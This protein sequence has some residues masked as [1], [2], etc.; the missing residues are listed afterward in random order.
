VLVVDD[1]D[2]KREA[3]QQAFPGEVVVF[4]RAKAME[5][6][7]DGDNFERRGVVYARNIC[8]DLARSLGFKH[9]IVLDDDYNSGFYLR[10]DSRL[11]YGNTPRIARS[12]DAIFEALLEFYLSTP[13][14]TVAFSQG[15]D[16]IGG[17][18]GGD[19]VPRLK[20]KAMNAF[21]C[22]VDRPF[23]F[24]GRTNEDVNAYVTLSRRGGLFFTVMQAQ[25]NQLA[26]QSNPGGLTELYLDSGTYV[27]SFYTVMYA[28][29]CARVGVLGDPR[30]PSFRLHHVI[31]WRRA[32]PKMLRESHRKELTRVC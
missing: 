2:P 8:W 12:L 20:R 10:F 7:D 4:S 1:E 16:H 23:A 14:L 28:P 27:K 25:V 11:R 32:A 30:S 18:A 22:T 26:T 21:V 13:A 24:F 19:Q 5:I 9:F 15:G 29:S 6:T 17:N 31:D 3:Y